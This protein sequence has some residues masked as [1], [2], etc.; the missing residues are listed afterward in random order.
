MD[1][2]MRWVAGVRLPAGRRDF[3]LPH[4]VQTG[5]GAY[6]SSEPMGIGVCI[7]WCKAAGGEDNL[8]LVSTLRTVELSLRSPIVL[9]G[10]LLNYIIHKII[11]LYLGRY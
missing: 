5:S 3:S 10:I 7:P 1:K 6:L 2:A 9:H 4:S 11:L 8:R